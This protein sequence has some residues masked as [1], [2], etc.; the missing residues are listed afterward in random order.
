LAN[1]LSIFLGFPCSIAFY[2]IAASGVKIDYGFYNLDIYVYMIIFIYEILTIMFLAMAYKDG[3]ISG[4]RKPLKTFL[5]VNSNAVNYK[6]FTF[7]LVCAS[8]SIL[9]Y[10]HYIFD[11]ELI[12]QPRRLYELSRENFGFLFFI[13]GFFLRLSVL[14]LLM[15]NFSRKYT[16]CLII[17]LISI[18]TGA[19]INSYGIMMIGLIYFIVYKKKGRFEK[20]DLIKLGS[21]SLFVAYILTRLTFQNFGDSSVTLLELFVRYI[22][23]PMNNI[24]LLIQSFNEYFEGFSWGNVF[25][26]NNIV[27]HIPRFIFPEKPHMFGVF[28]IADKYFPEIVDLGVGAPSFGTEGNVFV[29]WGIIGMLILLFT[30]CLISWVQGRLT[31]IITIDLVGLDKY[32]FIYFALLLIFSDFYLLTIPPA[33]PLFD[34]ALIISLMALFFGVRRMMLLGGIKRSKADD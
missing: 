14:L 7:I 23:E 4:I 29:D 6:V 16:L 8:I 13:L 1:G 5:A 9:L 26:E 21:V 28:S 12:S 15:S 32:S 18:F 24:V 27:S 11:F 3:Y 25:L 33:A 10:L 19:K 22:N 31:K 34:N 17:F 30:R 2:F 20:K